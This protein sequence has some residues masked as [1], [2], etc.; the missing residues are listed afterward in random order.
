MIH[1]NWM[2]VSAGQTGL[3]WVPV[4]RDQGPWKMELEY[5]P[6]RGLSLF[7]KTKRRMLREPLNEEYGI[8]MESD[9]IAP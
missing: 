1:T 3:V 4:M 9:W 7:E 8:S 5:F 6:F 2:I